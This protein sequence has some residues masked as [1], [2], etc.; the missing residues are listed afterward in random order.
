MKVN[1][2]LTVAALTRRVRTGCVR[3][4]AG[5]SVCVVSMFLGILQ[6]CSMRLWAPSSSFDCTP[7]S[8]L[9]EPGQLTWSYCLRARQASTITLGFVRLKRR[10][11]TNNI[12]SPKADKWRCYQRVHQ[13][14]RERGRESARERE[15]KGGREGKKERRGARGKVWLAD[16]HER[17]IYWEG[18]LKSER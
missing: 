7:A 13:G 14:E 11:Q 3:V 16:T 12:E 10:L 1:T 4:G 2:S 6:E 17:E 8:P 5:A 18:R 9:V 15:R